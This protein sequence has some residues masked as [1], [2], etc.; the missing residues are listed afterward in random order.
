MALVARATGRH[1]TG[2]LEPK[3]ATG[4]SS[5]CSSL[6]CSLLSVAGCSLQAIAGARREQERLRM[7]PQKASRCGRDQTRTR[8]RK[9]RLLRRQRLPQNHNECCSLLPLTSPRRGLL[10][11][12]L[13]APPLPPDQPARLIALERQ[14]GPKP[15]TC[16]CLLVVSDAAALIADLRDVRF[17]GYGLRRPWLGEIVS[18]GV[19]GPRLGRI[20]HLLAQR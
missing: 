6:R 2:L 20:E 1:G 17:L 5:H 13:R 15:P 11:S 10:S 4:T 16:S 18:N 7:P 9:R 3:K 8:H 12:I 14:R 19:D